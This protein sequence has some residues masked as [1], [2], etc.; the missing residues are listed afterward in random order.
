MA[1]ASKSGRP[2]PVIG[3]PR[4]CC[5]VK[6]QNDRHAI[7]LPLVHNS[8]VTHLIARGTA[9]APALAEAR[10]IHQPTIPRDPLRFRLKGAS[11]TFQ[12]SFYLLPAN[13]P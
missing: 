1:N 7:T 2:G 12:R 10:R 8:A 13:S 6:N 5:K 11:Q 9:Q 3:R 4:R